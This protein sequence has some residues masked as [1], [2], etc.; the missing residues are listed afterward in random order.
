MDVCLQQVSLTSGSDKRTNLQQITVQDVGSPA[1]GWTPLTS[2]GFTTLNSLQ[3]LL[4]RG[5]VRATDLGVIEGSFFF[6]FPSSIFS[7]PNLIS[8]NVNN[9][10]KQGLRWFPATVKH[11]EGVGVGEVLKN[12]LGGKEG[13]RQIANVN[14]IRVAAV[15]PSVWQDFKLYYISLAMNP[16]QGRSNSDPPTS[17]VRPT[18]CVTGIQRSERVADHIFQSCFEFKNS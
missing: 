11:G 17:V 10:Q 8:N 18:S 9:F 1:R 7:N 14:I 5:F 13:T 16:H 6:P 12:H 4:P 2:L 3:P 15:G